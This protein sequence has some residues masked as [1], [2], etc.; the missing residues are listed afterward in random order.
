MNVIKQY[1]IGQDQ[2]VEFKK[3]FKLFKFLFIKWAFCQK[4]TQISGC[5]LVEMSANSNTYLVVHYFYNVLVIKKRFLGWE[6]T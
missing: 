1:Q 2:K 5:F 3:S 6:Q 4:S